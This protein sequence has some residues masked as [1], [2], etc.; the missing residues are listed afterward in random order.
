[1]QSTAFTKFIIRMFTFR[2]DLYVTPLHAQKNKYLS[3]PFPCLCQKKYVIVVILVLYG[4][5]K[6]SFI[7]ESC[8]V[9]L[10]Y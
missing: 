10:L 9:H 5:I 3:F 6:T 2:I 8:L 4:Y 7:M 1:M